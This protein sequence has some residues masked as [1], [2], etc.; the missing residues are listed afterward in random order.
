MT[1]LAVSAGTFRAAARWHLWRRSRRSHLWLQLLRSRRSHLWLQSLRSRRSLADYDAQ[2]AVERELV[3]RLASLLWR[4]AR[5]SL[6]ELA[7]FQLDAMGGEI[8]KP[9]LNSFAQALSVS[10][11]SVLFGGSSLGKA[12]HWQPVHRM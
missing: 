2:S 6:G 7:A 4:L 5:G 3:L 8:E 12:F 11:L 9:G 1:P 10:I